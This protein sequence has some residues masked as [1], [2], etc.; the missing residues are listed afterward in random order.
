M[1]VLDVLYRGENEDTR[2]KEKSFKNTTKTPKL[3]I[4]LQCHGAIL[5]TLASVALEPG[6]SLEG[7][8]ISF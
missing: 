8:W 1:V 2:R 5:A 6:F 7:K 4:F 3:A